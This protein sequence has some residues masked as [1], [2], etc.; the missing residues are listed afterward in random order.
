MFNSYDSVRSDKDNNSLSDDK[1]LAKVKKGDK[2]AFGQLYERYVD[3]IYKYILF[4]VR[5]N[6][7][8]AE[9][10]TEEVFLRTFKLVLKKPKKKGHFR[11]LVYKIAHNIVIDTY[12]TE[13]FPVDIETV[14]DL[15][16]KGYSPESWVQNQELSDE[17][18]EAVNQLKPK[19]KEVIILRFVAGLSIAETAKILDISEGYVRVIQF[20]ALQSLKEMI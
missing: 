7:Q 14:Q 20:R 5:G 13:K 10:L 4:Q 16:D 1:L 12:R 17:L 18:A 19:M 3:A 11:A 15:E 9:D 2:V 6:Q 8:I